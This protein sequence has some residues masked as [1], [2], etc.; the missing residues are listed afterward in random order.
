MKKQTKVLAFISLCILVLSTA[1]LLVNEFVFKDFLVHPILN[2]LVFNALSFGA[3]CIVL[4][5]LKKSPWYFFLSAIL[6]TLFALYLL[7]VLV[8]PWWISI[9][10]VFVLFG[11]FT[12]LSYMR[13]GNKTEDIALNKSDD[14]KNYKEREKEKVEEKEEIPELKSFK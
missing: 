1:F 13:C 8:D 7:L 9:I 14:Y 4:A 6:F 3:L 12:A 2:F 11:V 10:A 5:F